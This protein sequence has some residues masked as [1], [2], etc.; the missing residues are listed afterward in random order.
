MPNPICEKCR[1]DQNAD[2]SQV[3]QSNACKDIYSEVDRCMKQFNGNISDCREQ[4]SK[5]NECLKKNK[6]AA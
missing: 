3:I 4:W 5:F 1:Q 2:H 6:S